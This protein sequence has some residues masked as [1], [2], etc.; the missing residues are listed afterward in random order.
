M[1]G[2]KKVGNA[3]GNY[4]KVEVAIIT[5]DKADYKTKSIKKINTI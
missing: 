1:R 3:N 5:S 2:R 4:K